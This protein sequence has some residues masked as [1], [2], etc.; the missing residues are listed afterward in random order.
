[1]KLLYVTAT[2]PFNDGEEFLI[3]EAREL[4]RQGVDLLIV[5]RSP[6]GLVVNLDAETLRAVSLR[7]HIMSPEVLACAA[8][9]VLWHPLRFVK[10]L[11]CLHPFH[12]IRNFLK[13]LLVLPKG[14]W[15][16]GV[17][18]RWGADHIHAHWGTTTS[19]MAMIASQWSGISWSFTAHR[20]DVFD[21]NLVSTKAAKASF[22]RYISEMTRSM[23][24]EL[25]ADTSAG[26]GSV[27]HMG[28]ALPASMPEEAS[29]NRPFVA[30]CPAN[31]YPVKGH[32][33]LLQALA[34]LRRDGVKCTVHLAG[35][36]G[37]RQKLMQ[38]AQD[39]RLG[40]MVE[41]LGS[42]PHQQILDWYRT[43]RYDAVVL[44]SVDLGN[45]LHEGIP[46]ALMEAMA[47]RIPVISTTTGGIPELLHDGAGILVPH[48]NPAALATAIGQL[49]R[50]PALRAELGAAG[51]K[52]I[53]EQF[54]VQRVVAE[55]IAKIEAA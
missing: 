17:A 48:G 7:R 19:T 5:P 53:E 2:M 26:R 32:E 28:V 3:A 1:M 35:E 40:P 27:I 25:G 34:I 8:A 44:P 43:G 11:R 9:Q 47:Y 31:L 20:G 22:V 10:V 55:L 15:L 13:N 46:V 50:H 36:G 37:L 16:A 42:V 30:L 45:H 51:R 39:L 33:H 24:A 14:L 29:H 52:R 6:R 4:L 41:F 18:R 49:A 12:G 23:M 38:M 21:N 54:C